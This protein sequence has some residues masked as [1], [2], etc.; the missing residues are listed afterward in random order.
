MKNKDN[1]KIVIFDMDGVLTDSEPA[2][3]QASIE[4]LKE[5]N[6]DAKHE[7]FKQ[8]TGM[9]DDKFIGGA[10]N[11]YGVEYNLD[12]KKRA[13]EIYVATAIERVKVF[14]WSKPLILK[15]KDA[16]YTLAIASASDLT[17]VNCNI[18]CIGVDTSVFDA[19]VTG[20]DV[21]NKK[22]APDI[23]LKASEKAGMTAVTL[24]NTIVIEDALSGCQAAKS[25][26]A[27]C[28]AVTTSFSGDQL[29]E[30]GADYITDDLNEAFDIIRSVLTIE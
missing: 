28:I 12:M 18:E 22:P 14:N 30:A 5:W 1:A 3:T 29:K 11:I 2:I 13:Y 20:S 19:I 26:G 6:V 7:D 17:K 4:S 24:D 10:A 21:I 9:G 15:L 16:G 25:A 23:F 27:T 8:F